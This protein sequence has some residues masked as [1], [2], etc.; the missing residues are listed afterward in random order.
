MRLSLRE[1]TEL[2]RRVLIGFDFPYGYP[3]EWHTAFG[4]ANDGNWKALWYFF[5]QHIS[6]D[7]Q[8]TNNRCDVANG[9]N[10][11]FKE[12]LATECS[13]PPL[14]N[15]LL[16]EPLDSDYFDQSSSSPE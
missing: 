14:S 7:A 8:N 13:R 15:S 2:H 4:L 6:D 5:A 10:M 11:V 12:L 9:L 16:N 1:Y 3:A